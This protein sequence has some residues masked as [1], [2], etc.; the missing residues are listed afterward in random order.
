MQYSEELSFLG[1]RARLRSLPTTR[2]DPFTSS[3]KPRHHQS[4]VPDP[5]PHPQGCR[6]KT[7]EGSAVSLNFAKHFNFVCCYVLEKHFQIIGR[8]ISMF[9]L[10][11]LFGREF[12]IDCGT[13]TLSSK[14]S[15]FHTAILNFSLM[16]N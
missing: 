6:I 9:G 13:A 7:R 14:Q 11:K 3:T 5:V 16:F 10:Q 1:Q 15:Q 12:S 4:A 2:C 8:F